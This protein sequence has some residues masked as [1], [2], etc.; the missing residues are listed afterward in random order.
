[1]IAALETVTDDDGTQETLV[2]LVCGRIGYSYSF[3]SGTSAAS[4][5]AE[6][7]ADLAA[8]GYSETVTL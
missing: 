8:R 7:D 5:A 4:M 2:S 3:P 1:M 6:I